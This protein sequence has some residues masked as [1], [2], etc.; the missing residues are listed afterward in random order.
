M[1]PLDGIK[2]EKGYLERLRLASSLSTMSAISAVVDCR[3]RSNHWLNSSLLKYNFLP[4]GQ[5]WGTCLAL[6]SLYKCEGL[7]SRYLHASLKFKTVFCNMFYSSSLL[8]ISV[9]LSKIKF[10]FAIVINFLFTGKLLM[11]QN[12]KVKVFTP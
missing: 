12:E 11:L 5:K 3:L 2:I 9:S 8:A 7:T 6:V 4:W 10:S 1:L